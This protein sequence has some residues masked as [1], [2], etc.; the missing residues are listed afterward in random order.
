MVAPLRREQSRLLIRRVVV[1]HHDAL[2]SQLGADR[3]AF[4]VGVLVD[5]QALA[6]DDTLGDDEF[7]LEDRDGDGTIR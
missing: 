1:S 3:L 5:D 4:Y 2:A 7:L 6:H